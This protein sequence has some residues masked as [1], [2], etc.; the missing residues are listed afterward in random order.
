MDIMNELNYI[1]K[2]KSNKIEFSRNRIDILLKFLHKKPK[3]GDDI[4]IWNEKW[5]KKWRLKFFEIK[6]NDIPYHMDYRYKYR[7]DIFL[8]SKTFGATSYNFGGSKC[9]SILEY[10]ISNNL[11]CVDLLYNWFYKI[12]NIIKYIKIHKN[13][14]RKYMKEVIK[15]NL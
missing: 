14:I 7:Y 6:P 8:D 2:N 10:A 9:P 1:I 12:D 11:Y 15:K 13:F 5:N 4:N 3:K